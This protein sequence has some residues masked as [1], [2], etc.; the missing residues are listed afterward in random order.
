M[1]RGIPQRHLYRHAARSAASSCRRHRYRRRQLSGSRKR[2]GNRC[3]AEKEMTPAAGPVY[4][5]TVLMLYL[6]LPDTP[7]RPSP[8]DQSLASKLHEQAIRYPS[9][10]PLFCSG[11][12]VASSG[13]P[14]VRRSRPFVHWPT[15]NRSLPSFSSR[16]YR[17]ATSITFDSSFTPPS[18]PRRLTFRKIR[19]R[20]IANSH[21]PALRKGKPHRGLFEGVR[22]C[23]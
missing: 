18:R 20:M 17:M 11:P 1:E 9:S 10:R 15:F 13:P 7:L 5:A 22:V 16:H 12:C 2:A 3:E 14:I 4:V 21:L 8:Q 23:V 6:D 19:F